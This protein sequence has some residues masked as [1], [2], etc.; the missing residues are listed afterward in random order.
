M[1][2]F[3]VKILRMYKPTLR[4]KLISAKQSKLKRYA[5]L[6]LKFKKKVLIKLVYK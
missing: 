5:Y 1:V 3:S 2:N 6:A 4:V